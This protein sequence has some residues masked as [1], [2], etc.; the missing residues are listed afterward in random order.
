MCWACFTSVF[1]NGFPLCISLALSLSLSLGLSPSVSVCL[2][3]SL[4]VNL[5][6][7]SCLPVCL[8]LSVS[9]CRGGWGAL[10]PPRRKGRDQH[11]LTTPSAPT[12]PVASR[13]TQI[14]PRRAYAGVCCN[15]HQWNERHRWPQPTRHSAHPVPAQCP[16]SARLSAHLSAHLF[17]VGIFVNPI[18]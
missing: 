18:I 7:S 15:C 17:F 3:L 10:L 5:S 13:A 1:P 16:P 4:S 6:V 8:S 9:V 2:C 11:E 14:G 12:S